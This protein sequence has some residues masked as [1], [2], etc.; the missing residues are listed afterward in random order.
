MGY[1]I[2]C[3][4]FYKINKKNN[5]M[6]R[7]TKIFHC[8]FLPLLPQLFTLTYRNPVVE[9]PASLRF[10]LYNSEVLAYIIGRTSLI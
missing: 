2:R 7:N 10:R 6:I 9:P 3:Q 8:S 1:I 4:N 5:R